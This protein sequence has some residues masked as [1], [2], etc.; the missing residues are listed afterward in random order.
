MLRRS[1][2]KLNSNNISFK[3]SRDLV[4][5]K[6]ANP[7]YRECESMEELS[8]P[9]LDPNV[10]P[11]FIIPDVISQEDMRLV[12]EYKNRLFNRLPYCDD[13]IDALITNYKE[14]YRSEQELH[15][16]P[17][18]PELTGH[19]E[20]EQIEE[21][22]RRVASTCRNIAQQHSINVPL[23]DRVH[24]LQLD[25]KGIIKAHA[26][27]ERN[28]SSIVAGLCFSSARVMTLTKPK[29]KNSLTPEPND[30][31]GWIEMLIQPRSLYILAG[32]ARYEWFHSVDETSSKNTVVPYPEPH[33]GDP[34]WFRGEPHPTFKREM[35]SVM[36]WRGVSPRELFQRRLGKK[37][38]VF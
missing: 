36:I 16:N 1:T 38:E 31:D 7:K 13:H 33:E 32:P 30:E 23:A 8:Q 2:Q 27:E 24:F 6:F 11:A 22:V 9:R 10:I 5:F 14:F 29:D 12:L 20:K 34:I 28:S 18:I 37:M 19:P 25:A 4:S 3:W 17:S 21:A 26:D 15:D 35:R